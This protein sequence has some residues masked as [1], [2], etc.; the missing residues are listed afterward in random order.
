MRGGATITG[1]GTEIISEGVGFIGEVARLTL[2]YDEPSTNS[3]PSIIS[4]I[5][6]SNEGFKSLGL[7]LGFYQ[8]EAG[9]F[10]EVAPEV[11]LRIPTCYYNAVDGDDFVLLLEDLAPMRPANQLDSCTLDEARLAIDSAAQLH[12]RWWEHPR[13][14]EF[15]SWLPAPGSEYFEIIKG[16]YI[17]AVEQF[18]TVFGHLI[19][20]DVAQ[21]VNRAAEDFDAA[22]EA[23]AGRRP[24]TFTHGDFRLDNMMFGDGPDDPPIAVL[25]WQLPFRGNPLCDIVYFLGG[26]FPPEWRREHQD[27]LIERYHEGLVEGG[28]SGYSLEEC[29]AD[30]RAAGLTLLAYMVTGAN[31]IDPDTLT[32]R[33]RDLIETMFNRYATTI[34][35]LGSGDFL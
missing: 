31:D 20:P 29:R 26:N 24:H 28:V 3:T 2:T 34:T 18:H 13:L 4:K 6:T 14:D 7:M 11:R 32:E 17:A 5:P 35:D 22:L 10:R 9:F 27:Q 16:G 21:L 19:T 1:V 23:G 15:A 30:Y 33:G 8:K 25:D 12:S